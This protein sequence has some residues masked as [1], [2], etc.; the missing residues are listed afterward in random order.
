MASLQ[1]ASLGDCG[2]SEGNRDQVVLEGKQHQLS[3]A[4]QI[5]RLHDVVL[6]EFDSLSAQ[7]Q[8]IGD[9][10]DGISGQATTRIDTEFS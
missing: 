4:L 2:V 3:I 8:L 9:L 10:L 7:V 5:E 6:V 1:E